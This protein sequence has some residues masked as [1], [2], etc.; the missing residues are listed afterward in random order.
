MLSNVDPNFGITADIILQNVNTTTGAVDNT[1]NVTSIAAAAGIDLTTSFSSKSEL[2]INTS[3]DGTSLTFMGYNATP[4]QLDIFYSN[5]PG[6]LAGYSLTTTTDGLRNLTGKVNANG[7]VTLYAVT[8]TEGS[9]LGGSGADPNQI[10]EI[11]DTLS[12]FGCGRKFQGA[13]HRRPRPGVSRR[14]PGA[15][16][17]AGRRVAAAQR[18]RRAG[19]LRSPPRQLTV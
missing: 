12:N 16:S 7:S 13:R 15:G 17:A 3:L 6:S 4:G 19:D 5:T 9:V 11:T 18:P 8:S 1:V 2:A 14:R 10:V